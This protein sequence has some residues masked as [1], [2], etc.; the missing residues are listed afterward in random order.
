MLGFVAAAG[1]VL[2][3]KD[4]SGDWQDHHMSTTLVTVLAPLAIGILIGTFIGAAV[5]AKRGQAK[6]EAISRELAAEREAAAARIEVAAARAFDMSSQQLLALAQERL[7]HSHLQQRSDFDAGTRQVAH[8][9]EPISLALDAVAKQLHTVERER[10]AANANLDAQLALMRESNDSLRSQTSQLVTALQASQTR[11][12]W[13]ETQLRRVVE[14][15]GMLPR[16]DFAEQ[17][18]DKES[19]KRPDMVVRLAGGKHLVVDAKVT[20]LAY[21]E[22]QGT[23]DSVLREKRLAHHAAA[24]RAH[25][26]SLAAKAYWDG[27]P[28][29]P[30]FVI[31]FVPAEP[32]F[33]AAIET[34]PSLFEYAFAKQVV[35]A[36]PMTLLAILRTCAYAWRQEALAENAQQVLDV[37]KQLHTRLATLCGHL[38]TLGKS[39]EKAGEAY[40]ATIGALESRVMVSARK[41]RDL[42]VVDESL[43]QVPT[44]QVQVRGLAANN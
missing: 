22:A 34:D 5:E 16:V 43:P 7:T 13:G 38:T 23:T 10:T 2:P 42:K 6:W 44:A 26:D 18:T 9:V 30:E 39:I 12:A 3:R 20:L 1:L 27:L 41:L 36:T 14:A 11:G 25:V 19:G 32:F 17:V 28:A 29:T 35:I 21:L 31:M 24:F 15:A 4:V 8:L 37:G 40:N 33:A